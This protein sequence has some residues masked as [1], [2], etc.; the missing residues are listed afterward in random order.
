VLLKKCR[1]IRH[2]KISLKIENTDPSGFK[3]GDP[4]LARYFRANMRGFKMVFCFCVRVLRSASV[5]TIGYTRITNGQLY[6]SIT[7]RVCWS[8]RAVKRNLSKIISSM[9]AS[10][11]HRSRVES[12]KMFPV[13]RK[14]TMQLYV[15][16]MEQCYSLMLPSE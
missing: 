1:D 12:L 3:R 5:Q 13:T 4:R 7:E 9:S 15:E 10:F 6:C 11:L 16:Y 8:D 14:Y 2:W